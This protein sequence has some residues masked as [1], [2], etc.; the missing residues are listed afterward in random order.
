VTGFPLPIGEQLKKNRF[1]EC[2]PRSTKDFRFIELKNFLNN[3]PAKKQVV[4]EL[5]DN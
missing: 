2:C 5:I 3:I 1:R 4:D